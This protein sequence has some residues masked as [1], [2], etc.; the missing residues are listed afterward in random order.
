MVLGSLIIDHFVFGGLL[1]GFADDFGWALAVVLAF[2]LIAFVG[3]H[4]DD[5]RTELFVFH[6]WPPL[7]LIIG[8]TL[9]MLGKIVLQLPRL[10][11]ASIVW[12]PNFISVWHAFLNWLIFGSG[13]LA[14][15]GG[16]YLTG[17]FEFAPPLGLGIG[18]NTPSQS[19]VKGW[20]LLIVGIVGF[21]GSVL[22]LLVLDNVG[23]TSCKYYLV[24]LLPPAT[25]AIYDFAPWTRPIPGVVTIVAIIVVWLL[26]YAWAA[27]VRFDKDVQETPKATEQRKNVPEET[28]HYVDRLHPYDCLY[29]EKTHAAAFATTLYF[30]TFHVL[31]FIA[32][33][34]TD[35]F[36]TDQ[37]PRSVFITMLVFSAVFLVAIFLMWI[38]DAKSLWIPKNDKSEE[39]KQ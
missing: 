26:F 1:A 14:F 5:T 29:W 13:A 27:F 36:L 21:F 15:T 4:L 20:T 9:G 17:N 23:K 25:F 35:E 28:D 3:V 10:I 7:M 12:E 34:I 2:D 18:T 11:R 31:S 24:L 39:S 33:W 22:S 38:L 19:Q 8:A 37:N 32:G 6:V 30:G 16:L